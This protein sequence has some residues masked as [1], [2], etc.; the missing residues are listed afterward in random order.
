MKNPLQV[1]LM[2]AL[3]HGTYGSAVADPKPADKDTNIYI[4][5]LLN[6]LR[7]ISYE[8]SRDILPR[9]KTNR[10]RGDQL[11]RGLRMLEDK[12]VE[13]GCLPPSK[14]RKKG[15]KH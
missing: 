2:F 11:Y 9:G 12:L 8:N 1:L 5:G 4:T 10:Q 13:G 7:E 14:D 3:F 6:E 15:G